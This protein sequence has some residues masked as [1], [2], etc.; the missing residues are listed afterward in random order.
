[1]TQRI[2]ATFSDLGGLVDTIERTI[3]DIEQQLDT[4]TKQLGTL[5]QQWTGGASDAFQQKV[6]QWYVRPPTTCGTT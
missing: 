2:K 3:A 5:T 1:M 6:D 4:L